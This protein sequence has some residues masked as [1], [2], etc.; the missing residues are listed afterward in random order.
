[1]ANNMDKFKKAAGK[2]K[3]ALVNVAMSGVGFVL[4]RQVEN[5]VKELNKM[6][7]KYTDLKGDLEALLKLNILDSEFEPVTKAYIKVLTKAI[8]RLQEDADGLDIDDDMVF[9]EPAMQ[10]GYLTLYSKT[11][12]EALSHLNHMKEFY[13]IG[14]KVEKDTERIKKEI[15]KAQENA[16]NR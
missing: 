5:R 10:D 16:L 9:S 15:W 14:K 8:D 6:A 1:M 13:T 7:D 2:A 11:F 3:E 12:D 4:K